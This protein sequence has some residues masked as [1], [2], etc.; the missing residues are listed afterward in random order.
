LGKAV[1]LT[2]EIL[3]E[4]KNSI[5]KFELEP[6]SGGVFEVS[7][8]GQP[9]FSKEGSDRFPEKGEILNILKEKNK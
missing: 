8:D 7:L 1:S 9:I 4:L 3:S 2:E 6:G 5:N